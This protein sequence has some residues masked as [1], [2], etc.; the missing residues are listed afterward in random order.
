MILS[1]CAT[2]VF[3]K[4]FYDT[5]EIGKS[6][7]GKTAEELMMHYPNAKVEE[8][9]KDKYRYTVLLKVP[10]SFEEHLLYSTEVNRAS[11]FMVIYF[12]ANSEGI[13]TLYQLDRIA[14]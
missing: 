5:N 8:Y 12:F 7:V 1:S 2:T 3:E 14:Y 4:Q 6:F 13:I 10:A 9:G 11:T